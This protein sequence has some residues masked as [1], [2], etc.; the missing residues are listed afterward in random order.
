[1]LFVPSHL[2]RAMNV[3]LKE[4]G[5]AYGGAS[6]VSALIGTLGGGGS[7]TVWRGLIAAGC[8]GCLP[9]AWWPPPR[10]T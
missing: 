3:D 7:P 10:C 4:V 9:G 2:V 5:A 1:M 8:C 6:A